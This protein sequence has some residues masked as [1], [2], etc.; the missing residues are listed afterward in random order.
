M[1]GELVVVLVIM[2]DKLMVIRMKKVM[3]MMRRRW[4]MILTIMT[5]MLEINHII[6]DYILLILLSII[7]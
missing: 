4:E 5:M 2:P 7:Y 6:I 1:M 3:K